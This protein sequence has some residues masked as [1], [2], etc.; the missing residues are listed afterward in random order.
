MVEASPFIETSGGGTVAQQHHQIGLETSGERERIKKR[1]MDQRAQP[2]DSTQDKT[3]NKRNEAV[4]RKIAKRTRKHT[5]QG[6]PVNSVSPPYW[7]DYH[8]KK[9]SKNQV[10]ETWLDLIYLEYKF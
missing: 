7:S 4:G 5:P 9:N 10:K 1:T 6:P 3:Q 8:C 2:L